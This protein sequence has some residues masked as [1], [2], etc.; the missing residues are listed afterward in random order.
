[1]EKAASD[2]HLFQSQ[3]PRESIDLM[4]NEYVARPIFTLFS[5]GIIKRD[6]GIVRFWR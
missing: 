4:Q 1:M 6:Y 3:G 2:R 5:S